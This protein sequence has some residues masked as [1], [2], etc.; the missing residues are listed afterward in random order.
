MFKRRRKQRDP[1]PTLLPVVL[2]PVHVSHQ[3]MAGHRVSRFYFTPELLRSSNSSIMEELR[4]T[5]TLYP[6]SSFRPGV[7]FYRHHVSVSWIPSSD[8]DGDEIEYLQF[9]MSAALG[10]IY[11]ADVH[12]TM[13][14]DDP[15]DRLSVSKQVVTLSFRLG[16]DWGPNSLQ[17]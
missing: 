7:R 17:S 15:F 8:E 12:F 4:E 13:I 1:A 11:D 14:N 2:L 10:A 16:V 6:D 3:F 9:A 5:V